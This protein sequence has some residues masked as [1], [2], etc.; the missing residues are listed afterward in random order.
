M[1][2]LG[3]KL[4][5]EFVGTFTLVLAGAGCV[6]A[7]QNLWANSQANVGLLA[8][9]LASGLAMGADG[10]R[11]WTRIRRP[12][13]SCYHRGILGYAPARHD[14]GTFPYWLAQLLGSVAAAFLLVTVIPES[15][16]Q[17]SLSALPILVPPYGLSR[18]CT[19]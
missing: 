4:F 14:E 18:G 6:C 9:A 3:Q 10:Q 7:D 2:S 16:W 19:R 15:V 8:I 12:F 1:Y 11:P 13:Q 5:V 17:P